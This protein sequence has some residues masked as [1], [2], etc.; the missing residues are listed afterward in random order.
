MSRGIQP[1]GIRRFLDVAEMNIGDAQESCEKLCRVVWN[2]N[3]PPDA[4]TAHAVKLKAELTAVADRLRQCR[5]A[6]HSLSQRVHSRE[7]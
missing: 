6:V 1:D 5:A 3:G 7:K 4:A 2:L